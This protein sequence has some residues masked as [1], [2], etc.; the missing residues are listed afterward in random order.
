MSPGCSDSLYELGFLFW[1]AFGKPPQPCPPETLLFRED[2]SHGEQKRVQLP[3][4][5][6]PSVVF[7]APSSRVTSLVS[8]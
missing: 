4:S 7:E 3:S 2:C 1:T 8:F 5:I 6:V